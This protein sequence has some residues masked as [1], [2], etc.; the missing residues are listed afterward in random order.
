MTCPSFGINAS[1]AAI[2]NCRRLLDAIGLGCA[3]RPHICDHSQHAR[4]SSRLDD[5]FPPRPA[6]DSATITGCRK[7]YA[8]LP[9][10]ELPL[11]RDAVPPARTGF[12][13]VA[14]HYHVT[15]LGTLL[16]VLA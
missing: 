7:P 4:Q 14:N 16:D 10:G 5:T 3:H 9:L 11:L 12:I 15:N 13:F 6:G 8:P 2:A 1:A